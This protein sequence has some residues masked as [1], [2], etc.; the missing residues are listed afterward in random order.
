MFSGEV[1]TRTRRTADLTHP[2]AHPA[3]FQQPAFEIAIAHQLFQNSAT[4]DELPSPIVQPIPESYPG[5]SPLP[6]EHFERDTRV[7]YGAHQ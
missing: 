6:A 5:R 4:D 1:T 2:S 3:G 7:D